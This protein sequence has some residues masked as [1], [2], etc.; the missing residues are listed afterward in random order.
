MDNNKQILTRKKGLTLIV[1]PLWWDGSSSRLSEMIHFQRPDLLHNHHTNLTPLNPTINFFSVL[2]IP[3]I[4]ELMQ[5]SYARN[6]DILNIEPS[7]WWMGEKFDGVRFCW[8]ASV[9]EL[10]T[11]FGNA[12][13]FD[14]IALNMPDIFVDGELWFGRGNYSISCQITTEP[15]E[16]SFWHLL[17]LILFDVPSY[18]IQNQPFEI[19]FC[20]LI[21]H[22]S[23]DHPFQLIAPRVMCKNRIHFKNAIAHIEEDGGEGVII[24]K[25]GSLYERDRSPFLIKIKTVQTDNEA[26]VEG[27]TNKSM[28]LKVPS[29][30]SFSIPACDVHVNPKPKI[31]DVVTYAFPVNVRSKMQNRPIITKIRTDISWRTVLENFYRERIS[32]TGIRKLR[33]H[34]KFGTRNQGAK[35]KRIWVHVRNRRK[36]FEEYARRNGFDPLT[37]ENWYERSL[38]KILKDKGGHGVAAHYGFNLQKALIDL[39]PDIGLDRSKFKTFYNN[40]NSAEARR[41]FLEKFASDNGFDPLVPENWYSQQKNVAATM[42]GGQVIKHHGSFTKAI[43]ELFPTIGADP[44]KFKL[45]RLWND[46]NTRRAFLVQCAKENGFDPLVP[47]NWYQRNRDNFVTFKA[48]SRIVSY[49]QDSYVQM[50]LDLFPDIGLQREKFPTSKRLPL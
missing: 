16:F 29:G 33:K 37:A 46:C 12:L 26:I 3:G 31:G 38:N 14:K 45:T 1:V 11:R 8:N 34:S 15:L 47:E 42:G 36:F 20:H 2:K 28:L 21:Q 41:Q 18:A 48:L 5:A 50:V 6:N 17:R 44:L 39:F 43:I 25:S 4:G 10:Y 40:L 32:D 13:S 19:R 30:K 9:R 22:I 27:V 7:S 35:P 49:H 24:R 23:T